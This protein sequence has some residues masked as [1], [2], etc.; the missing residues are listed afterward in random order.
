M[1][2]AYRSKVV[3]ALNSEN[4]LE[5]CKMQHTTSHQ[6]RSL[7][8]SIVHHLLGS[9]K[10]DEQR[11]SLKKLSKLWVLRSFSKFA[12]CSTQLSSSK[13][14]QK[15]HLT[16]HDRSFERDEQ[17]SWVKKVFETLNSE[18]K[19]TTS[20]Q[21]RSFRKCVL[22]HL[23]FCK[24]Q[25]TTSHQARSFK[26]VYL[27]PLAKKLQKGWAALIGQKLSKLWTLTTFLKFTNSC[28]QL[29]IK[30]DLSK[31]FILHHTTQWLAKKFRRDE[32]HSSVQ[33]FPML[34]ILRP[35]CSL[36]NA[37]IKQ[38]LVEVS[39]FTTC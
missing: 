12:K 34:W 14:F 29:V 35:S 17:S 24:Q 26:K 5:V 19:H 9:F 30:Q 10:W 23:E 27:T 7:K 22:R 37:V 3:E 38:D 4:R 32:Q 15:V 6:V 20:H 36:Q 21:A 39:T 2:S 18:N 16:P 28:T 31:K 13:I 25:H 1:S 8:K 33:N 11:S